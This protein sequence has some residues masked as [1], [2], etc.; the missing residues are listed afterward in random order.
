MLFLTKY[1]SN[2]IIHGFC[3]PSHYNGVEGWCEGG[4]CDLIRKFAKILWQQNFV[5]HLW[6]DKPLGV[7]QKVSS[8]RK[9]GESL[10]REQKRTG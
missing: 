5:L 2:L 9:G 6:Q 1:E 8:W 4:E 10:E 3:S 7:I